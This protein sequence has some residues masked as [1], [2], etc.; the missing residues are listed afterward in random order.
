MLTQEQNITSTAER[1]TGEVEQDDLQEQLCQAER[2]VETL[3]TEPKSQRVELEKYKS[4]HDQWRGFEWLLS[5]KKEKDR[6]D[7]WI[8]GVTESAVRERLHLEQTIKSLFEELEY[9]KQ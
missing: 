9:T 4:L 2:L 3:K 7:S 5:E 1:E 8:I 6:N